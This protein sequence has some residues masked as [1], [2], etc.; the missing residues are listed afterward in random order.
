MRE[1]GILAFA[2]LLGAVACSGGVPQPGR[3]R[4]NL[5]GRWAYAP[6]ASTP[7]RSFTST[8]P[9]P[10]LVDLAMPPCAPAGS[11]HWYK[12]TF[13][14]PPRLVGEHAFLRIGP[15]QFGTQVMLNGKVIGSDPA[16]YVPQ[17][18][19]IDTAI[20][21]E[22]ANELLVR[23][24]EKGTLPPGSALCCDN[25]KPTWT[26]GIW[27]DAAVLFTGSPRLRLVQIIP[28]LARPAGSA[29][30]PDRIEVR[31]TLEELDGTEVAGKVE[32][33]VTEAAT[34]RQVG[35]PVLVDYQVPAA[36]TK[37]VTGIVPIPGARYWSPDEPFLYRLRARVLKG[38]EETDRVEE[39]FGMREFTVN[40]AD[41]R[42]NGR[43][44]FLRGSN[45]A[46]HRLLSS[47]DRAALPWQDTW[48]RRA[49]VD[50][51]R[52]C[53]MNFFRFHLGHAYDRWYDF[54]D[55]GGILLQDEWPFFGAPEGADPKQIESEMRRW[56]EAN[57]NHPSIV[58]WDALN[59]ANPNPVTRVITGE[60]IP[61]LKKVDPTRLW[62]PVDIEEEH[63]YI[64]S[65]GP[66]V[67][68]E[69][70]GYS[71]SVAELAR[72]AHPLVLNEFCWFWLDYDGAPSSLMKDV[73]PRWLGRKSTP[74]QRL[75][76]QAYL[77]TELVELFRRVRAD[78]IQPFVYLS[79][80][81]YA[82]SNWF[83]RPLAE[84]KPKPI[85]DAL[86]NAFAPFGISLATWDQHY[87]AGE[88]RVLPVHV[89][90]DAGSLARGRLVPGVEDDGGRTV[91]Q[92]DAIPVEVQGA[93]QV[94]KQV[95]FKLP[96]SPGRYT[97]VASLFAFDASAPVAA[98]R[99]VAWVLDDPVA[100]A[101][102]KARR[103]G[104]VDLDDEVARFLD[105][106]GFSAVRRV[107]LKD[108][109]VRMPLDVDLLVVGPGGLRA[110]GWPGLAGPVSS[111]IERGGA[112]V[113]LEPEFGS[114]GAEVLVLPNLSL[115][116][117]WRE[118]RFAGGY[119][120]YF[121]P[122]EDTHPL[123][124]GLV[125][126]QLRMFSGDEGEAVSQHDVTVNQGTRVLARCGLGL[127]IA[128]VE[129]LRFGKGVVL[130]CRV[131]T[132]GRLLGRAD[133]P[134]RRADP[135]ARQLF[136]NLLACAK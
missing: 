31:L 56:V 73:L 122:E 134:T 86:R 50:L 74:E 98:S 49:L 19:R 26:P 61:R 97:L 93:D 112:L 90:N 124:S 114:R 16:C 33:Q 107:N 102:L 17:E 44:I 83:L 28:V 9:V 59:E 38:R 115:R 48:I 113:I 109:G 5:D 108:S 46:F 64:Y 117:S 88:R 84:L 111:W 92:G 70:F 52:S 91:W 36:G 45:I 34:G 54:A 8:V 51:P 78:A 126:D 27:G 15:A 94:V 62:E 18:Y 7:P 35:A 14:V 72:G 58:I 131:Q 30:G 106:A 103:I 1:A 23:V 12:R 6:G 10:G 104:V 127:R 53:H 69:R 43:K 116:S 128:A 132:R 42:L 4:L 101:G 63:P 32:L 29:D 81:D 133:A 100:P 119:D 77:A 2:L 67:S 66:V 135:V 118:D 123:W 136:L 47:P 60:I 129:E 41:F 22:G 76:H 121:F 89:F 75:A 110:A 24:G 65:L 39:R 96:D 57:Q 11:Y 13:S 99:K 80:N 3:E 71:R 130:I 55:E 79:M 82:T 85:L 95:T 21:R 40:G 120:S 68:R 25:E 125:P 87:F 37:P 105:T 20:A